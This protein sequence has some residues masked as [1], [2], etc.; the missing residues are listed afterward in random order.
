METF[1][2]ILTDIRTALA[3]RAGRDR[4]LA[5][6]VLLV[7]R[8]LSRMAARFDRL[9]AL[10][11]AGKLPKPRAP[12]QGRKS[13]SKGGG[14]KLPSG[15]AWLVDYVREVAVFG[16]QLEHFLSGDECQRF[17]AEVPQAGRIVRPL[18][19]MLGVGVDAG[20][21][22]KPRPVWG[23]PAPG[24]AVAPAGLAIGWDGR[25]RWV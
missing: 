24:P 13:A 18:L 14:P 23:A 6:L 4:A 1:A 11:R 8:R 7:W 2:L 12:Q 19:R 5:A 17:L 16:G 22:R 25:L 9:V 10:W 21:P 15:P 3:A 20:K